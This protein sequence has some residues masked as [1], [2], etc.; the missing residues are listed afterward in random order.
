MK[1]RE[2]MSPITLNLHLCKWKDYKEG[3][4]RT[5]VALPFALMGL[6]GVL[7]WIAIIVFRNAPITGA[8]EFFGISICIATLL[9][10]TSFV[11]YKLTWKR[12]VIGNNLWIHRL[13]GLA[14]SE[15]EVVGE[16]RPRGHMIATPQC[17]IVIPL[18][19]WFNK[20]PRVWYGNDF[21][22]DDAHARWCLGEFHP[23]FNGSI[24]DSTI[25]I[26]T[27]HGE[28]ASMPVVFALDLLNHLMD[29]NVDV[30]PVK[31]LGVA[32]FQSMRA[33]TELRYDNDA[34]LDLLVN[35]AQ[36]IAET[37]RFGKSKE[38]A[39][40]REQLVADILKLMPADDSR[41]K[42]IGSA[43]NAA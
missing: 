18:G 33:E 10:A 5:E 35:T 40:I 41:R 39:R 6:T 20:Q 3:Y 23:A 19:G 32:F 4:G 1:T 9:V 34:L 2:V 21:Q 17:A 12:N 15:R 31:P 42:I 28:E 27:R 29:T 24:T 16:V 37:K 11:Y 38:G 22:F 8:T 30:P 25:S 36:A 43:Q 13:E 7:G 14:P 26:K